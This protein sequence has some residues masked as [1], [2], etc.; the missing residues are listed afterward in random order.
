MS[1]ILNTPILAT[2]KKEEGNFSIKSSGIV[3]FMLQTQRI[4]A[5][6]GMLLKAIHEPLDNSLSFYES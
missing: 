2:E 4:L 5:Y 1:S 3:H 6:K